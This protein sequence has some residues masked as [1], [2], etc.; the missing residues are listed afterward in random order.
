MKR[1]LCIGAFI[2]SPHDGDRHFISARKLPD[3]YGV[4]PRDCSF[5]DTDRKTPIDTSGYIPLY[6]DSTGE[7]KL[8]TQEREG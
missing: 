3:L 7:Y 2:T 8:P 4:D 6:P 1:Y 5:I